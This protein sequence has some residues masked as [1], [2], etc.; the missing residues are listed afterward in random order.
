MNYGKTVTLSRQSILAA[1]MGFIFVI[2]S[3]LVFALHYEVKAASYT[4]DGG[5]GDNN[6]STAANWSSDTVPGASDIA[7]FDGTSTKDATIDAGFAGTVAGIDIN[8]GYTGTITQA[9]ALTVGT[10]RF[11]QEGGAFV[12][13]TDTITMNGIVYL[14]A[15]TFTSTSGTLDLNSYFYTSGGGTFIHNSGTVSFTGSVQGCS[16]NAGTITFYNLIVNASSYVD[17]GS[18]GDT[19]VV[20]GNLDLINGEAD[21]G[22]IQVNGTFTNPIPATFDGGDGVLQI[23]DAT[24]L[25]NSGSYMM[26]FDLNHASAAYTNTSGGTMYIE[27]PVSVTLGTFNASANTTRFQGGLTVGASGTFN[28]DSGSIYFEGGT[29]DVNTSLTL[30]DL[31]ING[32]TEI[33]AG[34]TIVV[35]GTL[36]LFDGSIWNGTIE[37]QADIDM[38]AFGTF[39]GGTTVVHWTGTSTQTVDLT[40]DHF[41]GL[42]LDNPNVTFTNVGDFEG[43]VTL[44]VATTLTADSSS[45]TYFHKD[46]TF[47]AGTTFTAGDLI[48]LGGDWNNNGGTFNAGTSTLVLQQL[49]NERT[50][51]DDTFNDHVFTGDNTFYNFRDEAQ[52]YRGLIKFESG[53]TQTITNYAK[54]VGLGQAYNANTNHGPASRMPISSTTSG[55]AANVNFPAGTLMGHV[56]LKDI[57]NTGTEFDCNIRCVDN[58]GNTSIDFT[59]SIHTYVS[60]ITNE[61]TEA[62]GTA[63]FSVFLTGRPLSNVTIP[64]ASSDETEG[65]PSTSSLTFTSSNWE[66]AQTVTVTGV[67]DSDD[68]GSVDYTIQL[69]PSTSSDSRF[70]GLDPRDVSVTNQDD[71]SSETKIDF[72][73][74]SDLDQEDIH[75]TAPESIGAMWHYYLDQV[76]FYHDIDDYNADIEVDLTGSKVKPGCKI[77]ID[78]TVYNINSVVD[79]ATWGYTVELSRDGYTLSELDTDLDTHEGEITVNSITCFENQGG[80]LK[81]NDSFLRVDR[82]SADDAD[83]VVVD[84]TGTYV[85]I[86]SESDDEIN[87]ITIADGT[88]ETVSVGNAPFS[89][90]YDSSR[91]NVWVLNKY[92]D[93][94]SVVNAATATVTATYSGADIDDLGYEGDIEYDAEHDYMWI[95]SGDGTPTLRKYDP[96]D[97]S[98]EATVNSDQAIYR[99]AYD[100]GNDIVWMSTTDWG[101]ANAEAGGDYFAHYLTKVDV[102]SDSYV[103]GSFA[104]SIVQVPVP[105]EWI[106]SLEYDADNELLWISDSL[107]YGD[108]VAGSRAFVLKVRTSDGVA[109]EAYEVGY[110]SESMRINSAR[111]EVWTLGGEDDTFTVYDL[112]DGGI[113][114]TVKG[115]Y[116]WGYSFDIANNGDVWY[117][118]SWEDSYLRTVPD[119]VANDTYY[120]ISSNATTQLDTTGQGTVESVVVTETLNSQNAYYSVSFDDGNSYKVWGSWRT[121]ASNK[122]SDHGGTEGNWYYRDNADT[123]AAAD[124]NNKN[125]A[126]SLAVAAG[127]NNQ[128]TGTEMA[129]LTNTDWGTTGGFVDGSTTTLDLAAT[130]YTD[131][132]HQSPSVESVEFTFGAST[133]SSSGSTPTQSSSLEE[134]SIEAGATCTADAS[135]Q[136]TLTAKNATQVIVANT[137]SF[138]GENWQAFSGDEEL[139]MML[140]WDLE[141]G[142]GTKTVYARFK[143]ETGNLSEILSDTI[144][145]DVAGQCANAEAPENGDNGDDSDGTDST[146]GDTDTDTGDQTGS[147]TETP[148]MVGCMGISLPGISDSERSEYMFGVSPKTGKLS[149]FDSIVPGAVIRTKSSSTVYCVAQDRSLRPFMDE[150][151]YFTHMRSFGDVRWVEDGSIANTE[152]RDAVLPREGVNLVKFSDSNKVY[153]FDLSDDKTTGTLHWIINEEKA[154]MNFGPYWADYVIDLNPTVR[155]Q[156]SQGSWV[157]TEIDTDTSLFRKRQYLNEESSSLGF[158]GLTMA[159][160]WLWNI[161]W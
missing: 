101:T 96:S 90:A 42:T 2:S 83:D 77:D 92:D 18:V 89:M 87:I 47:G 112:D 39:D 94:V 41:P 73:Q 141:D 116:G 144:E 44:N 7:V 158:D 84:P 68:D 156:F 105:G 115:S 95:G 76:V 113:S 148:E 29:V 66:T 138:I 49:N 102:T 46:F 114:R 97:G 63:T 48:Y 136:L 65:T 59:G 131:D 106:E 5:G 78:G 34:D 119:G 16:F 58:G 109:T 127:A 26:G 35:P 130:L 100:S 118:D 104:N 135:V 111:N 27:G 81:L 52:D 62:G 98:L 6:W 152:V 22:T 15:G 122:N 56:S 80:S 140:D 137:E 69:G 133:A 74:I 123:W 25:V 88:K 64:V 139:K 11:D 13:G 110:L 51:E 37:A 43:D 9:T 154:A 19:V 50:T 30:N 40:S 86:A 126:I 159:A 160:K 117:C 23:N 32:S 108:P 153:D 72:A 147:E 132:V 70:N 31:T 149:G 125:S 57:N 20:E 82:V 38:G 129:A 146:D 91:G 14:D 1:T 85:F 12:G 61:T 67:D 157:E 128:M 60:E 28:H 10:S 45:R 134:L 4:W 71:D 75:A 17:F 155:D 8:S 36:T 151:I 121:I 79:Y 124:P 145:L 3:I 93:S 33:G 99:M 21:D 107:N 161:I 150:T 103:G 142:D 120:T 55:V 143:S 24:T 53:S 54:I